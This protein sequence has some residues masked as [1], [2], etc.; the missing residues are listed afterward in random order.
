MDDSDLLP[1]LRGLQRTGIRPG[2]S[3]IRVLME[4]LGH[5]ERAFPAVLV[6]GTNGKGSTT[7]FLE[8]I[9]RAAGY[10]TGRFT[11]PHLTHPRERVALDGL[12]IDADRFESLAQEVREAMEGSGRALGVTFFEALTAI[13]FLA[14][15][16]ARVDIG[17]IEVGMG[18]RWDS[19]NVCDPTV[20]ILT[21]VALDHTQWLGP[22]EAH[23]LREKLGVA[24]KGR[25]LLTGIGDDLFRE[26]ARPAM[27]R[28]GASVRRLGVDFDMVRGADRQW[29]YHSPQR[30]VRNLHLALAG[31][32]QA[33]NAAMAVAAAEALG[34]AGFPVGDAAI[35]V[36]LGTAWWPGRFQRVRERPMVVLDGCH[37]PAGAEALREA[38][39]EAAM[40]GPRVLVHGSRPE[41][42]VSGV[43]RRLVPAMDAVIETSI[44]GLADPEDLAVTVRRIAGP[45]TPVEVVLDAR[46]AVR[47]AMVRA[48]PRG[49]VLVTGSLY[50]LGDLLRN[51]PWFP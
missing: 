5:P 4:R 48:G 7:A 16:R 44:P 15:A 37:N 38:I 40:P 28:L 49:S 47:Q 41:K 26:V 36:G 1:A 8:A 21:N 23:I 2:L 12:P 20:S 51:P 31:P 29:D 50:L 32:F 43:L 13:G 25:V 24:R 18:G 45:T 27:R 6:T 14:F 42:D 39:G 22:T 35:R 3:R 11:S 17:V 34:P 33:A 30:V 9:L 10:R 19:T 46:E